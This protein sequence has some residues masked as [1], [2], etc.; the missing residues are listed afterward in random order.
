[1]SDAPADDALTIRIADAA[2]DWPGIWAIFEPIV[3]EGETYPLDRDLSEAGA[4]AYWFAPDKTL[5]VADDPQQ[6]PETRIVG[7]YYIKPNSTG[8]AAHVCNAGYIVRPDQRG[9]GIAQ[10]LCRHS[11]EEARK[12]GYRAMQYNLV[13]STNDRAVRL[14]KHMGFAIVGRLPGAF[15]RPSGDYVNALVMYRSLVED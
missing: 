7:S 3:R 15:R 9:R 8:P 2:S 12:R 5:F 10:S 6:G 14:W 11:I 1:M 4:R 13:I